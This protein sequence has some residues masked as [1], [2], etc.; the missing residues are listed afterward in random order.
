[1]LLPVTGDQS[2]RHAAEVA[3]AD[4]EAIVD[5]AESDVDVVVMAS[6]RA[7]VSQR[8]SS[9]TEWTTWYATLH[10]KQR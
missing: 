9:A 1:V 4:E 5:R 3:V 6:T 10:A 7:A 2:D 8:P